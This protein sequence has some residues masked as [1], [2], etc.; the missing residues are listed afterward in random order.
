MPVV[1]TSM[2]AF[3]TLKGLGRKQ[4][5]IYKLLQYRGPMSNGDIAE[6]LGAHP[7]DV[8]G[9]I[10]ELRS[11]RKVEEAFKAPSRQTNKRVCYW[12]VT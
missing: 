4:R 9:R 12:C 10:F 3:L 6:A 7:S 5:Q 11:L 1:Q 8:T 2:D